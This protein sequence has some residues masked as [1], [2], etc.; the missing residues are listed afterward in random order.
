MSTG[1]TTQNTGNT[2]WTDIDT[3]KIFLWNNQ[4][5][6]ATYTNTT[7]GDL[8]LTIGTVLGKITASGK[9]L[10]LVAAAVDGSEIP[11]GV[12]AETVTV[13]D[14]ES[15]ELNYCISG[16]VAAEL[17]IFNAAEGLNTVVDGRTLGDRLK[18]DTLGI[19]AIDGT[20]LTGFDNQ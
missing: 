8:T 17:L 20:E 11:V 16:N 15:A 3:A 10:P 13:L 5:D 7:G 14:T 1:T 6:V 12:L 18:A 2:L 19:N 4:Y 9:L